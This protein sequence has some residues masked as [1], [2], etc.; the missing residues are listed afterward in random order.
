[1]KFHS[2]VKLQH[3]CSIQIMQESPTDKSNFAFKHTQDFYKVIY[4][5]SYWLMVFI[6]NISFYCNYCYYVSKLMVM[7][8]WF[9]HIFSTPQ[10]FAHIFNMPWNMFSTHLEIFDTVFNMVHNIGEFQN[11][12]FHIF[13]TFNA[14][15]SL[16]V[17]LCS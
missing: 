13:H 9:W 2:K 6:N 5:A 12:T 4:V 1:M 16:T 3:I 17:M 11:C 15:S 7:S 14:R 8:W 10:N